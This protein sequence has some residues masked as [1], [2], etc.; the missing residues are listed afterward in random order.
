MEWFQTN[1]IWIALGFG[2]IAMHLFGH[3][4]HGGHGRGSHGGRGDSKSDPNSKETTPAPGMG[5]PS[6]RQP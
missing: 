1:W 6:D 5:D 2:F 4:G 3:A